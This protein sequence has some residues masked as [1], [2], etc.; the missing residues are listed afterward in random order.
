VGG[1]DSQGLGVE[2]DCKGIVVLLARCIALG[3]E[4]FGLLF[5]FRS[6]LQSLRLR[7][8]NQMLGWRLLLLRLL[9]Y[10]GSFGHLVGQGALLLLLL[11]NSVFVDT[12]AHVESTRT[13]E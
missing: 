1:H 2:L 7:R 12:E 4:L 9:S 8:R 11:L 13:Q 10:R 5:L 6:Y 3:V